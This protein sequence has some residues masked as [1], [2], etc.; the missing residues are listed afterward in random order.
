MASNPAEKRRENEFLV[1]MLFFYVLTT[2]GVLIFV[3]GLLNNL[4][5]LTKPSEEGGEKPL[6]IYLYTALQL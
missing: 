5:S 2:K 1:S 3:L 6:R 4:L